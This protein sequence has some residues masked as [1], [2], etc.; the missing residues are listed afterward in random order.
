MVSRRRFLAAGA[1]ATAGVVSTGIFGS[2][3][4]VGSIESLAGL[5]VNFSASSIRK[6]IGK[7]FMIRDRQTGREEMLKLIEVKDF[8]NPTDRELGIERE[9]YSLLFE[10]QK[11][12]PFNQGVYEFPHRAMPDS[13]LLVVPVTSDPGIYEVNFNSLKS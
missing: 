1:V 9:S 6:Q 4:G 8:E 10:G 11:R 12:E 5:S 3:P 13:E 2:V 7:S